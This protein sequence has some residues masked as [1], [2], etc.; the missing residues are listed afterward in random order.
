MADLAS[1][2]DINNAADSDRY[3]S[4]LKDAIEALGEILKEYEQFYGHMLEVAQVIDRQINVGE[5]H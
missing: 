4:W 1:K 3:S 2:L 5:I